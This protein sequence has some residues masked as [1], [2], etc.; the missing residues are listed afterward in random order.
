MEQ[1]IIEHRKNEKV[2]GQLGECMADWESEW[3]NKGER[4]STRSIE[5]VHGRI[6]MNSEYM[7][8]QKSARPNIGNQNSTQLTERVHG[9]TWANERV[10]D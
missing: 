4:N 7:A 8:D 3:P 10:H 1:C 9:L 6:W 5:R 2:D